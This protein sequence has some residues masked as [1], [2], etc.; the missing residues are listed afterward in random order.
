MLTQRQVPVYTFDIVLPEAKFLTTKI[1]SLFYSLIWKSL[2]LK[3]QMEIESH[4]AHLFKVYSF[5]TFHINSKWF[6]LRIFHKMRQVFFS[7]KF[8]NQ[9]AMIDLMINIKL[10]KASVCCNILIKHLVKSYLKKKKNRITKKTYKEIKS[11][12]HCK[13]ENSGLSTWN[14][15]LLAAFICASQQLLFIPPQQQSNTHPDTILR[16]VVRAKGHVSIWPAATEC[17]IFV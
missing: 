5:W 8:R 1:N 10:E 12:Q 4:L 14:L 13:V 15:R 16:C 3:C 17:W 6:I 9:S 2:R 11:L 7:F